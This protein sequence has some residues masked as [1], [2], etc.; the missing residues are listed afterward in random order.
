MRRILALLAIAVPL[1]VA[2]LSALETLSACPAASAVGNGA[3]RY[4][5]FF[6]GDAS[7]MVELAPD[8]ATENGQL[9]LTWNFAKLRAQPV[10]LV[11]SFHGTAETV[12]RAL[13]QETSQC[14]LKG[15]ISGDGEIQGSPT[16][17]CQ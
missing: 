10:T 4:A 11:C 3:F 17:T 13:P 15:A 7:E 12:Q 6:D 2:P 16:L 1:S 9:D 8:D 14:R 5:S